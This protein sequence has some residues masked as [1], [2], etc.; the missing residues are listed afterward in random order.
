MKKKVLKGGDNDIPLYS[1]TSQDWYSLNNIQNKAVN[2]D[3]GI[4]EYIFG[5]T[6]PDNKFI[7][8]TGLINENNNIRMIGAGNKTKVKNTS[9]AKVK[10][11]SKAKVKDTSKDTSKAKVKDTSNVK[12]KKK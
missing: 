7:V 3:V 6:T 9:K 4:N 10:N 1:V 5:R 12:T 8:A 2:L 11:T